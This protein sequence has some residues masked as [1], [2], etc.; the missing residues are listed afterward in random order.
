MCRYLL[1]AAT[2]SKQESAHQR[3]SLHRAHGTRT[4]VLIVPDQQWLW[5]SR[6]QRG[7]EDAYV[8][9][10]PLVGLALDFAV[11]SCGVFD[12]GAADVK[13]TVESCGAG[14]L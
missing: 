9:T 4:G 11:S 8:L 5:N 1:V 2:A 13:A 12:S 3:Q 6:T 7:W 10:V 14:N